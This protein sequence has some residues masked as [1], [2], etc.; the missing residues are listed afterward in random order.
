MPQTGGAP[1]ASSFGRDPRGSGTKPLP[2]K[3]KPQPISPSKGGQ[4]LAAHEAQTYVKPAPNPAAVNAALSDRATKLHPRL[5]TENPGMASEL[6]LG[7][8]KT[9]KL[10]EVSLA[11]YHGWQIQNAEA[12][13]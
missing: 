6:L 1:P 11:A 10:A 2:E 4:Q 13:R 5:L 8:T 3:P 9:A 7:P 12:L